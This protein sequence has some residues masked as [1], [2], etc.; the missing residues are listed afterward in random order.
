[1]MGGTGREGNAC[2]DAVFFDEF[3][4]HILDLFAHIN[5]GDTGLDP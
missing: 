2:F 3:S 5:D 1:M 4:V